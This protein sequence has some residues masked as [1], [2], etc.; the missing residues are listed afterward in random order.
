M[1]TL[2]LFL[3]LF[4]TITSLQAQILVANINQATQ[5]SRPNNFS[6]W[7][8][9][10]VFIAY[11]YEEGNELFLVT[12]EE[13]TPEV[14]SDVNPPGGSKYI[15]DLSVIDDQ[16]YFV[17]HEVGESLVKI[18][19]IDLASRQT[20]LL[21]SYPSGGFSSQSTGGFTK[22]G[23]KVF[24]YIRR[25]GFELW[26]TDGTPAGTQQVSQLP[27]N[28]FP[29]E[30]TAFNNEIY[31]TVH[32][33][34]GYGGEVWKSDGTEAGTGLL[35]EID[36]NNESFG[37]FELTVFQDQ[38]F[39]TA[40]DGVHG[41][42]LWHSDGTET[43]T[44][45]FVDLVPGSVDGAPFR[46][47]AAG[48]LLYFS[49]RHPVAGTELWT[50]DGTAEGT[51]LLLD[52]NPG[53]ESSFIIN[54]QKHGDGVV[55][56]IDDHMH[57]FE[58]WKSN[59]TPEGT[60][61]IKDI[62]PGA[63]D[64]LEQTL[65]GTSVGPYFYFLARNGQDGIEL[66]RTDGTEAGTKMI[67]DINPG[68][69][70]AGIDQLVSIGDQLYF[71]A[72]D[73]LLG[74]ELWT[75]DGSE[76][77]TYLLADLNTSEEGSFPYNLFV[78]KDMLTFS[79]QTKAEGYELW[80][81]Q[82]NTQTTTLI[83][84]INPG[85]LASNILSTI[86]LDDAFYFTADH[87][88]LGREVWKSDGTPEGTHILKDIQEGP[89]GSFTE[90]LARLNNNIFFSAYTPG[91]GEE[92]WISDGSEAGTHLL[93]DINPNGQSFPIFPSNNTVL[94]DSI[95]LFSA[96]DGT[97]GAE[98]WKT[99][100]T[101]EGTVMV[102]DIRPFDPAQAD[103]HISEMKEI[104]GIAYFRA[105]NNLAGSEP[106]RSDGTAEGTY[107]LRDIASGSLSSSPSG[108]IAF[109]EHIYFSANDLYHGTE[110]WRT[111]GTPEGTML[112]K[113]INPGGNGSTPYNFYVHQGTLF[114]TTDND[115]S[116]GSELWKSDG[117]PEG[118]VL[119]KDINPG[120]ANSLIRDFISYDT[121][122][123]FTA[124]DGVHGREL[125]TTDGTSEGTKMVF[126]LYP[127]SPAADPGYLVIY[128]GFL[129]FSAASPN[130][131]TEL[132]K[133]SPY[134]QDNDGF[135]PGEDPDDNDPAIYPG[136]DYFCDGGH[137]QLDYGDLPSD[138]YLAKETIVSSAQ[139]APN[140]TVV[141]KAGTSI[142]LRPPFHA[143]SG[144]T[145]FASIGN[146][147]FGRPTDQIGLAPKP[148]AGFPAEHEQKLE[149][150]ISPNPFQ[151]STKITYYLPD[152]SPVEMFIQDQTG[153][154]IQTSKTSKLTEGWHESTFYPQDLPAG[155]YFVTLRTK[156]EIVTKKLVLAR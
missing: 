115:G 56:R 76:S 136:A 64:A 112:L 92:L 137:L 83:K 77:G 97:H 78:F 36:I 81:T 139:I 105:N 109:Q 134:D 122:L 65:T 10:I 118:T 114:F 91:I 151:L 37:V 80:R 102:K 1:K 99:N 148:A 128:K 98:L 145:F 155:I 58:L 26:S 87:A 94:G 59:G 73:S 84:D 8:K 66:W 45:I 14:T 86:S 144:S 70:N 27:R 113:D 147:L 33:E 140:T 154:L 38:L 127:G 132:W 55:L 93:K 39:F 95:L 68:P 63:G 150:K 138:N 32:D 16:A 72:Q 117:T 103:Y 106:W 110:L 90:R 79:A 156:D 130:I 40:D 35:K 135:L 5:D 89:A 123:Y 133:Y 149:V 11:S 143:A 50:S 15:Y 131:R 146:C 100:G 41:Y 57:G 24:F 62:N 108:F 71:N 3:I 4:S 23:D 82:G 21:A 6:R 121:I 42:E 19:K 116:H 52:I 101:P 107:M 18:W 47:T 46:L 96:G 22:V 75:S 111:D 31:F 153:R 85:S 28:A 12:D 9:G 125:W 61:L 20:I 120:P 49:A 53:P 43:G 152:Q 104:A 51:Q 67:K 44:E 141:F 74:N 69:A 30:F 25:N 2:L 119:V 126:D 129:Y 142:T 13:S 48:G 60:G 88:A 17:T 54:A 34:T 29:Q 124:S 7:S